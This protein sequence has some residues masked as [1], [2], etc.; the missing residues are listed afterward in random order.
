MP[1]YKFISLP[2]TSHLELPQFVPLFRILR[3]KPV[4]FP[5]KYYEAALMMQS[6]IIFG[7][8]V[9]SKLVLSNQFFENY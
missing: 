2:A 6:W 4:V 1:F 3:N 8:P 5:G 7:S 9:G